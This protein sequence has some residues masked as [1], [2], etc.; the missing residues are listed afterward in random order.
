M[1]AAVL[2]GTGRLI[3]TTRPRPRC[4]VGGVLVRVHACGVCSTDFRMATVGHRALFHPRILGHE[5]SGTVAE[6]RTRR[7]VVGDRVQVAPGLRCGRCVHCRRGADQRCQQR[8]ILG[9]STDGGFAEYLAVSLSGDARGA[10]TRLADNLSFAAAA[11]AEP[12]AC[13]INAQDRLDVGRDDRVMV[14][15]AGLTGL[16]HVA[17]ARRR[18]ARRVWVVEPRQ[19]H[20]RLALSLGADAASGPSA[21]A[22][23]TAIAAGCVD[24]M[25]MAAGAMGLTPALASTLAR[26]ARVGLFSGLPSGP[27]GM[28]EPVAIHYE[29]YALIGRLMAGRSL[30]RDEAGRAFTEILSG[31]QSE[32]HQGAFLAAISAKGP[33][34]EEIAGAWGAIDALD[35]VH[36]APVPHLRLVDNCGTGMDGSGTFNISTAAALVAAAGGCHLAR[37]GARAVSS[38]CGTVDVCEAL[39]VDVECLAQTV[40]ASIQETG[41]GSGSRPSKPLRV[42][43]AP[44]SM[45]SL[46]SWL[47]NATMI[48]PLNGPP[49]GAADQGAIITCSW[50]QR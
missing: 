15:G 39:G 17:L 25:I 49:T 34:P 13:C 2:E 32:I 21:L 14:V 38:G 1:R 23:P 27:A 28:P 20:R 3:L 36:V 46:P 40:R 29:E 16:M 31:R 8:Q 47:R 41:T 10:V 44:G 18:G 5:I 4:P 11:L 42:P 9:F 37:H 30:T 33:T 6:S 19:A 35:T 24:V 48:R 7:F 26:G 22:A 50:R 43:V 12:L 45:A